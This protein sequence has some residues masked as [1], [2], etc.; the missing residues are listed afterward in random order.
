[1]LTRMTSEKQYAML[2]PWISN[3]SILFRNASRH[4]HLMLKRILLRTHR[5]LL[6]IPTSKVWTTFLQHL[7]VKMIWD[8]SSSRIILW[9]F[10]QHPN[11]SLIGR[12]WTLKPK[13][14]VNLNAFHPYSC[15]PRVWQI[16][17]N[18]MKHPK[19]NSTKI[20]WILYNKT[21]ISIISS[22]S[23]TSYFRIQTLLKTY[24]CLRRSGN[25]SHNR[26]RN[27]TLNFNEVIEKLNGAKDKSTWLRSKEWI[28]GLCLLKK[29]VMEVT[30]KKWLSSDSLIALI[31]IKNIL[32]N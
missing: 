12:C 17:V 19:G 15:R 20:R 29:D 11:Y 10:K 2:G 32:I 13:L 14:Y 1:M 3:L 26:A 18:S 21:T 25:N 31:N 8:I 27:L 22:W 4:Q 6:L 5:F 7:S 28:Y 9:I 23:Q 30:F 24:N 16:R